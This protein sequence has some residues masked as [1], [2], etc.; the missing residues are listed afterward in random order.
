MSNGPQSRASLAERPDSYSKDITSKSS[1]AKSE[2]N[3][4]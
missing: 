2:L 3:K 1:R 4:E